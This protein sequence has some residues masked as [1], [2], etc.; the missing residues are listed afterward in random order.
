MRLWPTRPGT[1][2]SRSWLLLA[3]PTAAISATP[4]TIAGSVTLEIGQT[5][6]D[7]YG[8]ETDV[9]PLATVATPAAITDPIT[10]ATLG[11][12]TLGGLSGYE[13]GLLEVWY[14]WT[15]GSGGETL[16][17]PPAQ[18]DIPYQAGGL[19]ST[20]D[21]TLP[22]TPAA[23]GAAGAN[24]YLRHRGGNVVLA[25][26]ILTGSVDEIT[27]QGAVADCYRG[28][29]LVNSTGSVNAHRH[30]RPGGPCRCGPHAHLHPQPGRRLGLFGSATQAERSR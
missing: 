14:S 28:S 5:F 9:G 6:V 18:V 26:R 1:G 20:V 7:V 16:P 30:H 2:R 4:G 13:G 8:R 10:A 25:Y 15:D 24:I 17:S 27:L 3:A 19:L 12:P 21:V 22:S 11:T 29:P 23:A